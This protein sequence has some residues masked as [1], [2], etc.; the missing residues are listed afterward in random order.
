MVEQTGPTGPVEDV[1][2]ERGCRKSPRPQRDQGSHF[3]AIVEVAPS[4]VLLLV[5]L[6]AEAQYTWIA[7]SSVTPKAGPSSDRVSGAQVGLLQL[8]GQRG[9]AGQGQPPFLCHPWYLLGD[10]FLAQRRFFTAL[11]PTWTA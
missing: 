8:L 6:G 9:L 1:Q 11:I 4:T 5:F 7:S 2:I 10:C 3:Q